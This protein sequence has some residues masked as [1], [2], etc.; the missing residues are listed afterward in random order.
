MD[1][2]VCII[3]K[4]E[5]EWKGRMEYME[6]IYVKRKD[7]ATRKQNS[8]IGRSQK[9]SRLSSILIFEIR[10]GKYR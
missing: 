1:A 6:E 3:K 4:V 2:I 7:N 10:I 8:I 9:Y 5:V